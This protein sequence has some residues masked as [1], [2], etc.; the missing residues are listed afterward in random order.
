MTDDS[1]VLATTKDKCLL[2]CGTNILNYAKTE[3]VYASAGCTALD[4]YVIGSPTPYC[5][6]CTVG[7]DMTG[8]IYC[9]VK[10]VCLEC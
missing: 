10:N 1:G 2:D 5:E 4:E 6:K 9:E 7:I 8:C 3:C